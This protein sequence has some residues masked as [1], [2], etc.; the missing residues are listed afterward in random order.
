M[1]LKLT[2]HTGRRRKRCGKVHI[3]ELKML[4]NKVDLIVC[5][6]LTLFIRNKNIRDIMAIVYSY[7]VALNEEIY[8]PST[9]SSCSVVPTTLTRQPWIMFCCTHNS[10]KATL[11]L[12]LIHIN[13]KVTLNYILNF[14]LNTRTQLTQ[15]IYLFSMYLKGAKVQCVWTKWIQ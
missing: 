15:V 9:P 2:P 14:M 4:S 1:L 5:S 7:N 12:F 6:L 3:V 10:H 11:N 13:H 8:E